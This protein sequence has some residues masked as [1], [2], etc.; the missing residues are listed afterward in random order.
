MSDVDDEEIDKTESSRTSLTSC[1]RPV[2]VILSVLLVALAIAAVVWVLWEYPLRRQKK[3]LLSLSLSQVM[4]H[5]SRNDCWLSI[6]EKVYDLTTFA[7]EHPGGPTFIYPY[8]GSNAT[9]A[10][11]DF[12]SIL[13]LKTAQSFQVGIIAMQEEIGK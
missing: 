11:Q 5:A 2:R 7:P 10:F 3:S 8:C 4:E 1:N 6:H 9:Q 13:T 12:H